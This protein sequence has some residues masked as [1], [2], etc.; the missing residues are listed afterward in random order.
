MKKIITIKPD[1]TMHFIYDDRLRGLLQHGPS[2]IKRASHVES[3]EDLTWYADLSPIG[4]PVL[5]GFDTREGALAAEIDWLNTQLLT[6]T[7]VPATW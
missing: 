2:T 4:G 1:G 6:M 3:S 7:P 5:R